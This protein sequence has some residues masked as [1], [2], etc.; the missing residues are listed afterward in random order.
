MAT[1]TY[2]PT[3]PT[4]TGRRAWG[5]S[6]ATE[7]RV[8]LCEWAAAASSRAGS[9]ALPGHSQLF[10]GSLPAKVGL[11]AS[12]RTQNPSVGEQ[13]SLFPAFGLCPGRRLGRASTRRDIP[14]P[15]SFLFQS[16]QDPRTPATG[17]AP[18]L[19]RRHLSPWQ[20]SQAR[21]PARR[22]PPKELLIPSIQL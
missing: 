21:L 1:E 6:R 12:P 18:G 14:A 9:L 11:E 3:Y 13:I 22:Q 15:C 10:S 4:Q 7:S 2:S 5:N 17:A 8:E 19:H 20:N 16:G